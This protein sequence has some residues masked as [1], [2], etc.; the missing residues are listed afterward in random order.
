MTALQHLK[1]GG[2]PETE[3]QRALAAAD[4]KGPWKSRVEWT[5]ALATVAARFPA[6]MRRRTAKSTTLRNVLLAAS[7]MARFG[8]YPNNTSIGQMLSKTETQV[9][10]QVTTGNEALHRSLRNAFRQV[11][12]VHLPTFQLKLDIFKMS[13]QIVHDTAARVPIPRQ[14]SSSRSFL[15]ASAWSLYC[16]ESVHN[17]LQRAA[18]SHY[19]RT[20]AQHA[21][22]VRKWRASSR[23][24][25]LKAKL[26][27]TVLT[28]ARNVHMTGGGRG[29]SD[30]LV[31]FF[32]SCW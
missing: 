13:R 22:R 31:T 28:R 21:S 7:S 11:Y 29:W 5:E 18:S 9:L 3:V 14:L 30:P 8:W 26:K 4:V 2:M 12:D 10:G 20:R 16:R 19:V 25:I 32:A 6:D 27:R 17:G 23:K 24:R 1:Y 15:T